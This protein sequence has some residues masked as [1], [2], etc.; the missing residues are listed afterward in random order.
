MVIHGDSWQLSE[1]C[2]ASNILVFN[3]L[4]LQH[5]NMTILFKKYSHV[6]RKTKNAYLYIYTAFMQLHLRSC[7]NINIFTKL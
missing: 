7:T 4:S 1:N 2:Y 5:N 6:N 3:T